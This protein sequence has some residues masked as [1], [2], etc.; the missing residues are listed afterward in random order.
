MAEFAIT[1]GCEVRSFRQLLAWQRAVDLAVDIHRATHSLPA[2]E[3]FELGRELRRSARWKTLPFI[4]CSGP[5]VARS[6]AF[7]QMTW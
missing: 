2:F 6:L 7:A 4:R 3:K 5:I 1:P